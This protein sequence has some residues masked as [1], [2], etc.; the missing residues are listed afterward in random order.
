MSKSLYE[1]FA[2]EEFETIKEEVVEL[3]HK[4][5]MVKF[6]VISREWN[7]EKVGFDLTLKTVSG[8]NWRF[9]AKEYK[10]FQSATG[11]AE[12]KFIK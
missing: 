5:K 2:V 12:I 3:Y 10:A 6:T 4:G 7:D 9:P 1:I 11:K 8:K